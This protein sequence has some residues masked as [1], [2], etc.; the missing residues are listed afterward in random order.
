[1]FGFFRDGHEAQEPVILGTTGGIPEN[2]SNPDRGFNDSR[3]IAERKNSPYPP[4]A[5]DRFNNGKPARVIEHA[6]A[7]E[8]TTYEFV[9]ETPLKGGKIWFGTDQ[10]NEHILIQKHLIKI[11]LQLKFKQVFIK[12]PKR[13]DQ[14]MNPKKQIIRL[15]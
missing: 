11:I 14:M 2:I 4:L 15:Y 3:T 12:D 6:Q 1:M 10:E 7:F 8:P 9:G 13:Q 5:I